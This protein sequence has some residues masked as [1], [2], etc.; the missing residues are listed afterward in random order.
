M[1]LSELK[2]QIRA[3]AAQSGALKKDTEAELG[4]QISALALALEAVNPTPNPT[5]RSDLF[6]GRWRLLF[7]TFNLERT[8]SL[9]KLSFGKLPDSE[10]TI[11]DVFQEVSSKHG[12]LYDN[13]VEFVDGAGQRG[14]KVMHGYYTIHD[15]QRLDVVFDHVFVTPLDTRDISQFYRDL[16]IEPGI[17]ISVPIARTPPMH[18]SL[19][20]LD[21]EMRINRGVY[22]GV[23]VLEKLSEIAVP[24]RHLNRYEYTPT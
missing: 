20:Y 6:D 21:D 24:S 16:N 4:E 1:T 15:G 18:S 17:D 19:I 3:L 5:A 10:V 8:A 22:G 7:S 2:T 13:V 23:Y 14:M 11:G 12:Q 9:A